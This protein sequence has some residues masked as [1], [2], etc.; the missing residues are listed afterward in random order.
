M[1]WLHQIGIRTSKRYLDE[2]SKFVSWC[3]LN[4]VQALP[5][6]TVALE[7]TYMSKV[8]I[9]Y[10]SHNNLLLVVSALKWLYSLLPELHDN[11]FNSPICKNRLESA[12]L[13]KPPIKRKLSVT[14]DMIKAIINKYTGLSA[15]LQDLR[16]ACLC[17]TAF[18]GFFRY[19]ETCN[20]MPPHLDILS[21]YVK[22]SAPRKG[23]YV[24]IKLL[25]SN[26][27]AVT[28]LERYIRMA[29]INPCK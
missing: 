4:K 8:Y 13:W 29:E 15:S 2:I 23:N 21:E 25:D 22:I 11:P 12:K 1:N 9:D 27:C 28:L 5:P 20:I 14:P 24:Y 7:V 17:S 19:N 6:F 18:T 10:H 16:I 3:G 26:Y